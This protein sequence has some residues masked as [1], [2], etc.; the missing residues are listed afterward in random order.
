MEKKFTLSIFHSTHVQESLTDTR[1]FARQRLFCPEPSAA[2][3][4]R[5]AT[6]YSMNYRVLWA[7]TRFHSVKGGVK[8]NILVG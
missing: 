1:M 4:H 7:K 3:I 5:P 2:D 6:L 8:S